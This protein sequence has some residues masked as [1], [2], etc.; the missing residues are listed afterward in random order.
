MPGAN[1]YSSAWEVTNHTTNKLYNPDTYKCKDINHIF[2][3]SF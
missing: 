3:V 1:K 2:F